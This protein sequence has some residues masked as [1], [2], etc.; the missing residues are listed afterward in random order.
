[1]YYL[2]SLFLQSNLSSSIILLIL[3]CFLLS[4]LIVKEAARLAEQVLAM[5]RQHAMLGNRHRVVESECF[6]FF[7]F[8]LVICPADSLSLFVS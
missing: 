1:M 4:Q 7:F 8:I 3:C 6:Y 2:F 5:G